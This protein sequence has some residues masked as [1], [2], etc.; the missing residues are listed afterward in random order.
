MGTERSTQG[1]T[2]VNLALPVQ[3]SGLDTL[4]KRTHMIAI[5]DPCFFIVTGLLSRGTT[6]K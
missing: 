4:A 2:D 1:A 6:T 3:Q 5:Q